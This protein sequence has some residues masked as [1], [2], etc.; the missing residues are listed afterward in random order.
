MKNYDSG[1]KARANVQEKESQ[2]WRNEVEERC[3]V[4]SFQNKHK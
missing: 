3:S 2:S 4:G 1:T